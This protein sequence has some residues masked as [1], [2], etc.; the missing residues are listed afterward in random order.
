[1]RIAFLAD[2]LYPGYGGQ[3]RASE[4]HIEALSRLGHEL[5]VL[6]GAELEPT[7]V[8]RGVEIERL[9]VWRLGSKQ[10]H[11]ALPGRDKLSALLDWAEIVQINTASPLT[12]VTAHFAAQRKIPLVIGF[13]AQEE[14]TS[15]SLPYL[16]PVIDL[17]MSRFYRFVYKKATALTAPTPFA[18]RLA[19]TY[20]D[21]PVHVVSNGI[22]LPQ[23]SAETN[24]QARD[25]RHNMLRT[26]DKFLLTYVGRLAH[27]KRPY[28][29]LELFAEL[30]NF[31]QDSVLAIAGSGPLKESLQTKARKLGIEQRVHFLGF[32][33]EEAKQALLKATDLFLI[34]S[35][36]ELQSIAT[37]EA[38][39]QAC[40]VVA[41]DFKSSAVVELIRE[42]GAGFGYDPTDIKAA[43]ILIDSLLAD[44]K[45]LKQLQHQARDAAKQY[46]L[47]NVGK[48]LAELY[49][50]FITDRKNHKL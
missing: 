20:T 43:A 16:R 19:K 21:S 17:F 2:D 11:I 26:E 24:E 27:E 6:A 18:A 15:L 46:D 4:G 28:D 12:L 7:E 23:Q 14:N 33:S 47:M 3:A 8:P 5:R 30:N 37:L 1:M 39:A 41:A 35:Q 50:S 48:Q 45:T 40:A 29:L 31:R 38:M 34:S 36:A 32:V 44:P 22:R 42:A 25:L 49:E 10:A 13:H 9:P